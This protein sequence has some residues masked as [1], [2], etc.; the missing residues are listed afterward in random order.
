MPTRPLNSGLS[1]ART[2]VRASCHKIYWR[3][4]CD[5]DR[6]PCRLAN[7]PARSTGSRVS[8]MHHDFRAR[9]PRRHQPIPPD[10]HTTPPAPP[11][12]TTP[13]RRRTA[14]PP[15]LPGA[16]PRAR[17]TAK[18]ALTRRREQPPGPH[19]FT[20]ERGGPMTPKELSRAAL[21]ASMLACRFRST[22]TCCGT[23]AASPGRMPGAIRA[24]CKHGSAIATS[25]I[26]GATRNWRQ[27]D[28][29]TSG[30]TRDARRQGASLRRTDASSDT[31]AGDCQL[32]GP[33]SVLI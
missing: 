28:S 16:P 4:W 27:T 7:L 22:R 26:R 21:S 33:A 6:H 2:D 17:E 10:L 15:E 31:T 19:V 12:A 13:R 25:S 11:A 30:A 18:R 14:T 23:R 1:S 20:S 5:L 3:E 29:R 24:P 32:G 9:E 8:Y